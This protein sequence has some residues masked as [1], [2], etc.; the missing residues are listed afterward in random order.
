MCIGKIIFALF[1]VQVALVLAKPHKLEYDYE[2]YHSN[3]NMED[4]VYK[5]AGKTYLYSFKL[6]TW[7]Q[8][9]S[10]DYS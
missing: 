10:N 3:D 7:S 5:R 6:Y 8:T 1:V 4:F 9:Y 2:L